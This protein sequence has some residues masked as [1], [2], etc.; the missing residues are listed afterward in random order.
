MAFGSFLTLAG[1]TFTAAL[2]AVLGIAGT[3]YYRHNRPVD[4]PKPRGPYPVGR[5][6]FDWADDSR[7]RE[8]MI[9]V[10]YPA[11]PGTAGSTVEYVPGQWGELAARP[12]F[13]LLARGVRKTK[14]AAMQDV[15][16]LAGPHPL[17][18]L[19]P[20]MGAIPPDYTTLAEDLASSGYVVA[21]VTPTGSARVVV[22]SAGRI[23]Y[24]QDGIDLEHPE[25]A[26]PLVE[27]WLGDFS[28][29]LDRLASEPMFKEHID[30]NRVGVLGH[31]FGGA[32]AM[33]ALR[34]DERFKRG[35]NLDGAP[36]G[37]AVVGLT[38]PL[39]IV[40]GQPLPSSQ[41]TLN[42]K[43]LDELQ[44]ICDSDS[45]GCRIQDFPEAGHMN[46]SDAAVWPSF[47]PIPRSHFGLTGI[48][49]SAFLRKI[50]DL[51]REFFDAM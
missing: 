7:H 34:T 42:A 37:A 27:S 46:F 31:S 22:F 5:V 3:Q 2:A 38:K 15:P 16:L 8:L 33:H 25:R 41:R 44:R 40:N 39:L 32:A 9:F 28:F 48:D 11:P 19:S 30:G 45:A 47:F 29:V 50:S 49:G 26:Q 35:V 23:V 20:A 18:I 14:V 21:G 24:G 12:A 17:L 1:L 4:L 13:P 36:Q 51:L 6:L 10:W 43:I